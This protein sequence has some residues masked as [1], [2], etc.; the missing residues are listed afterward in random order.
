[1]TYK[2]N[3]VEKEWNTNGVENITITCK[4]KIIKLIPLS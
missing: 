1:M 3:I 2:I 4:I